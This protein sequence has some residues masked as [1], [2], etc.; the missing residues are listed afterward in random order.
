[1]NLSR[2]CVTFAIPVALVACASGG[3]TAPTGPGE[4]VNLT[5]QPARVSPNAQGAFALGEVT[6]CNLEFV[7]RGAAEN[8]F[9]FRV[10]P[11]Q[12]VPTLD[13]CLASLKTQPGVEGVAVAR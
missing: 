2:L 9:Q 11:T 1:M 10:R 13:G 7:G 3:S 6:G 12:R 5:L 8:V 4:L